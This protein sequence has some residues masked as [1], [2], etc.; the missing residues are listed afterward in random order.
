MRAFVRNALL[1]IAAVVGLFSS[2]SAD[3][4]WSP[5]GEGWSRYRNE[6]FGTLVEV[7][8]HIFKLVEP[9]PVN[10]DGRAFA[11]QDGAQLTI[12][13]SY[14]PYVVTDTFNAYKAWLLEN[15]ELDRIT[16][17]AEGKT[18]LVLSGVKGQSIVYQKVVEGCGAAHTLDIEYPAS[19]KDLYDPVAVRMAR[20][21]G[22]KAEPLRSR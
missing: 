16:Y 10:G 13:G 18:W 12:S 3:D 1:P 14:G 7:P 21:L 15:A 6:R 8:L 4:T 2:A 20:S 22:C 5:T 11:S 17:R 9:P 19:Q